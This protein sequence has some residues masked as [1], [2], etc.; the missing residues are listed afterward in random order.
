[1]GERVMIATMVAQPGKRDELKALFAEMFDVAAGEAGTV[2][3]TLIEGDQP[4]TLYFFEQYADQAA[5]D[6]HM[7]GSVLG[8][9][10]EKLFPLLASGDAVTGTVAQKLR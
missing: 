8:A 7:G 10:R 4:D 2:L 3:Y 6:A 9:L 1:V 5:M